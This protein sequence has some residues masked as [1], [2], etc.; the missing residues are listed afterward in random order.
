FT[1]MPTDRFVES[2]FWNFD[3]L[4]QPQQHPARD[5]HDTFF[6]LGGYWENWEGG[7][8][9]VRPHP[10]TPSPPCAPPDPAETPQLP[11]GYAAKV[12]KIHSQ[13]GYGSQG[14]R[15]EWKLEEAKRN[16][17]RTHT[18]ASSARLLHSLAQQ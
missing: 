10:D 2:S 8:V 15:S 18:T 13:G 11:P 9:R 7:F 6:L 16:L 1:E 5:Q 12:K 17:L 14:Y 3:A 4:F